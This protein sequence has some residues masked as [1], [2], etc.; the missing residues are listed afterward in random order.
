MEV[1][2]DEPQGEL[3][4]ELGGRVRVAQRPQKIPMDRTGIAAHQ[5]DLRGADLL[6]R[7]LLQ[8]EDECP[9]GRKL[10]EPRVPI[11][12]FHGRVSPGCQRQDVT[13]SHPRDPTVRSY[14]PGAR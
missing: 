13:R 9:L 7:A 12:L 6:R 3:L 10:A 1:A 2:A 5:L 11:L 8:L 14:C 4:V